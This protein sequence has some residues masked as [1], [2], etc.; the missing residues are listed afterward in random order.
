[1]TSETKSHHLAWWR[2]TPHD[3]L[4]WLQRLPLHLPYAN[5]V[6]R[7]GAT[8][9]PYLAQRWALASPLPRDTLLSHARCS[10]SLQPPPRLLRAEGAARARHRKVLA[11]PRS[12]STRPRK[13]DFWR[14]RGG[15]SPV[16]RWTRHRPRSGAQKTKS[17]SWART[18]VRERRR[19]G[20]TSASAEVRRVR[21]VGYRLRPSMAP[22]D[23]DASPSI[24]LGGH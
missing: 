18:A 24:R 14:R 4:D 2:H 21:F 13:G 9:S 19:R 12:V 16:G 3:I 6:H 5:T 8:V 7:I 11:P 20:V 15:G 22:S 23:P 1:M 10:G 17:T